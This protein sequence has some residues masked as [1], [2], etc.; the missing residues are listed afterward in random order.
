MLRIF[1]KSGF[2]IFL[3]IAFVLQRPETLF[4]GGVLCAVYAISKANLSD[5][6]WNELLVVLIVVVVVV[7]FVG[8]VVVDPSTLK[9]IL[10]ISSFSS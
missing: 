2:L 5:I 7:I 4:F 6:K 1:Y 8:A 10:M 3:M 9:N